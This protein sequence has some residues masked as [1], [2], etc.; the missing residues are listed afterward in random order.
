MKAWSLIGLVATSLVQSCIATVA[1]AQSVD[2]PRLGVLFD[3][4]ASSFRPIVGILGAATVDEPIELGAPVDRA[5]VAPG[6]RFA[7][8]HARDTDTILLIDFRHAAPDVHLLDWIDTAPDRVAWSPLGT[9][10]ALW[11]ST[12][13]RLEVV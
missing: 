5:W 3:R 9:T 6:H 7:L 12:R 1:R 4:A 8:A 13:R 10:A 11:T 2:G